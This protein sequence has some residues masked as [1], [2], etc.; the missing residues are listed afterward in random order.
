MRLTWWWETR[1]SPFGNWFI[2]F[3][4]PR[5]QVR[6]TWS[7]TSHNFIKQTLQRYTNWYLNDRVLIAFLSNV[8]SS[9]RETPD[10]S[11]GVLRA[12][13]IGGTPPAFIGIA[14]ACRRDN[15]TFPPR[16]GDSPW[17]KLIC[18]NVSEA[19]PPS[20]LSHRPGRLLRVALIV[21]TPRLLSYFMWN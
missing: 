18:L 2:C 21:W 17:I 1:T 3:V 10:L 6:T 11:L 20:G 15:L 4:D 16:Y 8:F 7:S 13:N 12:P 9:C 14:G 19:P 5:S